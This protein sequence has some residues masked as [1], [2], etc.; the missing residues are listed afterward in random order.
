MVGDH[1]YT[2]SEEEKDNLVRV[3]W[4]AEGIAWYSA[5]DQGLPLYRLYN[6]NADAGSHHY[7]AS[8]EEKDNLV[9][10][11]WRYEGIAWYGLK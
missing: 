4:K 10:I 6:P 1:H 3:G 9:R 5:S 2:T 7:T 8:L 11:G